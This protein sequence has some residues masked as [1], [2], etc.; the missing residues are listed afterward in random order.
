MMR[1][2]HVV[3]AHQAPVVAVNPETGTPWRVIHVDNSATAPGNG[4]AE[5]PFTTLPPAELAAANPYDI[6]YVHQGV[7]AV[8]PYVTPA[9]GYSFSAPNQYLIGEGSGLAIPTVSCGPRSFFGGSG[10]YPVITN[11]LGAAIA[12]DQPGTFVS[13]FQIVRSPVGITDGAGLLAGVATVSDVIIQGDGPG[14]RGV[15]I[16]SSTGTF[17]FDRL[18]LR[19]LTNDGLL[20]S[21]A[22]GIATVTSST[23]TNVIGRAFAVTGENARGTVTSSR[24]TDT[25]GT[26]IEA[27]GSGSRVVLASSTV[28]GTTEYAVRASGTSARIDVAD[29]RIIGTGSTGIDVGLFAS[30]S[31][32]VIR[33]ERSTITS[34]GSDSIVASGDRSVVTMVSSTVANSFFRGILVSGS[35][36]EVYVTGTSAIVSPDSDGIKVS[37][38]NAKLLV[39]DTV[40]DRPAGDGINVESLGSSTASRVTVLRSTIRQPGITGITAVG[41]T[42]TAE[43]VQVY[44]STITEARVAGIQVTNSNLDVGRDPVAVTAGQTSIR[45]TGTWGVWINGQSRARINSTVISGVTT[46]IEATNTILSSTTS[47]TANRNT[48]TVDGSGT[49]IVIGAISGTIPPPLPPLDSSFVR[50]QLLSNRIST[51]NSGTVT[52]ISLTAN[53]TGATSEA[54]VIRIS[55]ASNAVDLGIR[56]FG[57]P[58]DEDPDPSFPWIL[59]GQPAPLLPPTP[60]P[61][62]PP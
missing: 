6:V 43:V 60:A 27:S 4:H 15:E 30:G 48:I 56:N 49:G 58:V 55:G 22:G 51:V 21:S 44:S 16:A 12:I 1:N 41:L 62:L 54:G 18:Q 13:H 52:G 17:V 9:A 47:L 25:I 28:A 7:S 42:G 39:Q 45:D 8:S 61:L 26:A 2:E 40:I 37:G 59:Y 38:S 19:D 31:G 23:F 33:M 34:T 50:A 57:T 46:G 35:N 36:A 53:N 11:P 20:L 10:A 24:F 32:S 14:Q 5:S 29:S 3:R